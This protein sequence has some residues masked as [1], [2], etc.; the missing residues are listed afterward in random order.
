MFVS[1]DPIDNKSIL[2]KIMACRQTGDKPLP[3]P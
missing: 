3:E 2:V 1:S